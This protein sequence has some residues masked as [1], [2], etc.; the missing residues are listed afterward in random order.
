MSG[1]KTREVT[2]KTRKRKE[3]REDC[4]REEGHAWVGDDEVELCI[5]CGLEKD[6]EGEL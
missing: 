4:F 2:G 5:H 3:T 6:I 1:G